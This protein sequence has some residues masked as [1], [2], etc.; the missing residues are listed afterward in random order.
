[1]AAIYLHIPFCKQACNYCDFHFSTSMKMKDDFV[2]AIIQ[3]IELRKDVFANE[4]ISSVYF[5][6]GTPSLLSKEEL[7]TIFEML[8]KSFTIAADAEITLEANPDDLTFEKIQQL[9]DS[10]VN[11]L[12]IGVQSFRDEDLKYMNRAHTAIEALNSIKMAQDAG[13]QNITID[14]IYGTPGMSN[15]DWKHN[16]SKSVALNIPHISSYALTVEEKTPL[17][18][19]ILKKNI[20]PVDEQQSADQF[21]IL[22][23]EMLIYGY[24]QYEISNFCKDSSYSKHN[25]SYWKKGHYLGLGPS[26]HS[27]FGNSRLW[28]ISNNVKYIKALSTSTLPLVK[29]NLN[30]QDMYNEYVMTSLRTKWG[31]GLIEIEKDYSI[32]FSHYFKAQIKSH[33][34]NGY[35]IENKGV[36]TLSETGKLIADRI[37]SDLFFI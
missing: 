13:F 25:S 17:Y 12:S 20:G 2:Q 9:K 4:F 33:E 11:R 6:G 29:E 24:E 18:Y 10:P 16:L 14:L 34:M 26:A 36:Y 3:E 28:N 21:K 27:Y 32:S 5:G 35:I 1:M 8:Y 7:D 15:E 22:M 23:A 37:T 30:T 19:Q 31:C